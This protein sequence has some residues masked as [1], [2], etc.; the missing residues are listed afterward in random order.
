MIEPPEVTALDLFR[1]LD[2]IVELQDDRTQAALVE[3]REA[4]AA[5]DEQVAELRERLTRMQDRALLADVR[6]ANGE[7]S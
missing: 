1:A 6:R 7:K 2:R 4:V 3:L 5:Q